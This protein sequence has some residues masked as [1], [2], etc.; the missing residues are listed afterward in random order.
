MKKYYILLSSVLLLNSFLA[1]A[2][3][4]A[5]LDYN[6]VYRHLQTDDFCY[7]K[8]MMWA[9][10]GIPPASQTTASISPTRILKQNSV[11]VSYVNI[12][13]IVRYP[14]LKAQYVSDEWS[15]TGVITYKMKIDLRSISVPGVDERTARQAIVHQAKFALLAMNR[16]M[17]TYF[18]QRYRLWITFIGLPKQT[19][20]AGTILYATTNYPYTSGSPLIRAYETELINKDKSC[21]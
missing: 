18:P 16:N 19:D 20:L 1:N 17:S 6:I 9:E 8:L 21:R 12:N 13:E 3:V 15:D 4:D 14:G 2:T 7:G 11:S 5:F 10:I